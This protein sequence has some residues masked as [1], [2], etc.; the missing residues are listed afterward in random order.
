MKVK[1]TERGIERYSELDDGALGV[2]INLGPHWTTEVQMLRKPKLIEPPAELRVPRGVSGS[3]D[4]E[5]FDGLTYESWL[6]FIR[7]GLIGDSGHW[8]ND[9]N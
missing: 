1:I 6:G 3:L 2:T 4:I 5:P 8:F 7:A 9:I